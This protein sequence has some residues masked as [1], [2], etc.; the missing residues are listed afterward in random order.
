MNEELKAA[1]FDITKLTEYQKDLIMQPSY[2]PENY[3]M[4]GEISATQANR[5]WTQKLN[6]SGLSPADIKRAKKMMFG[7]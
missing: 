2:A 5:I 4:D 3:Y 6:N 1:G 7:M